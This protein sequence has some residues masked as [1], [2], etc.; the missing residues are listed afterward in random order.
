MF[1]IFYERNFCISEIHFK[2]ED[3]KF[4]VR[5]STSEERY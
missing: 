5:S 2:I 3:I 4:A 1:K